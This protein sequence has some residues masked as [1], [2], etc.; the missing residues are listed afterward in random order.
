MPGPIIQYPKNTLLN[1]LIQHSPM[2]PIP[3]PA[4]SSLAPE[5]P[6]SMLQKLLIT[7]SQGYPSDGQEFFRNIPSLPKGPISRWGIGPMPVVPD[8]TYGT[9]DENGQFQPAQWLK[10]LAS[11]LTPNIQNTKR[12]K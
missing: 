5:E 12:P 2:G 7:R 6:L 11:P 4:A 3:L 9:P 10:D 8:L 1:T